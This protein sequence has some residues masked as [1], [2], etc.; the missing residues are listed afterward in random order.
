MKDSIK[1]KKTYLVIGL[2][3]LM[4]GIPSIIPINI[5]HPIIKY[6]TASVLEMSSLTIGI[7]IAILTALAIHD[8]KS[9][10]RDIYQLFGVMIITA[11]LLVI[12]L[13]EQEITKEHIE[14]NKKQTI[15]YSQN[16]KHE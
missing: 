15:E 2:V 4:L 10:E 7:I 12:G 8:K 14:H 16:N 1:K 9:T 13:T 5:M 11:I 6:I 3:A